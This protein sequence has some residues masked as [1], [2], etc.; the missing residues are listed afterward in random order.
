[1]FFRE[2]RTLANPH[3]RERFP[4]I[5]TAKEFHHILHPGLMIQNGNESEMSETFPEAR[6]GEEDRQGDPLSPARRKNNRRRK[7]R[8]DNPNGK[9]D[10]FLVKH[11]LC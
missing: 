11:D 10:G 5:V 7:H 1:M 3:N 4:L 6:Q 2:Q 9:G 8:D